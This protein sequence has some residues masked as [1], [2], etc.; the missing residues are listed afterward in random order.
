MAVM[1]LDIGTTHCKVAI[2]NREGSLLGCHA[3]DTPTRRSRYA[4]AYYDPDEVFQI[5]LS[6]MRQVCQEVQDDVDTLAIAGMA[7]A[8]LF[9]DMRSR[10]AVTDIIPWFDMRTTTVFQEMRASTDDYARFTRTGLRNHFKYSVYKMQWLLRN[11]NLDHKNLIWLSVPDYI[12]YRLTGS[13]GTDYSLAAR[14]YLFDIFEQH[15][16]DEYIAQAD[17]R[18]IKLPQPLPSGSSV[19]TISPA[20]LLHEGLEPLSQDTKVAICG[21]DHLCAAVAA[22]ATEP[23]ILYDSMGTSEVLLGTVQLQSLG[24]PE[25][26]TGFLFGRHLIGEHFHWMGST[27]ASGDSVEWARRL[28]GGEA[29]TYATLMALLECAEPGPTGIL[30]LPYLN[31]SSAP[32]SDPE[33]TGAFL[34]LRKHHGKTDLLKAVLEGVSYDLEWIRQQ[35]VTCFQTETDKILC[36]GGG[37][38]NPY[39]MQ[40]KADLTGCCIQ[41]PHL[42]EA[43]LTGAAIIAAARCDDIRIPPDVGNSLDGSIVQSYHPD[44]AR[45]AAYQRI[46]QTR[47]LPVQAPLR[48]IF[49]SGGVDQENP[50]D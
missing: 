32:L 24:R 8:G 12:A 44:V 1:A 3:E 22:G 13:Y 43:T 14:T 35:A 50:K 49:G 46:F 47:Y 34:G 33:M 19:G 11:S 29:D 48:Q 41:S 17:L 5:L 25:Y 9:V 36:V 38:R 31:G 16:V 20:I 30:Y 2:L 21:H 7:E 10:L 39:W 6:L 23:G 37:T 42:R 27:P 18:D 28:V 4:D 15:Y 40:I 26:E 45:R